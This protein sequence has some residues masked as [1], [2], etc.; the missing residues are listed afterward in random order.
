VK[1][2]N[3]AYFAN[4]FMRISMT[5]CPGP[6][7]N[8]WQVAGVTWHRDRHSYY[9][10]DYSF[11]CD[12]HTLS[13]AGRRAWGLLYVNETWWDEKGKNVVRSTHWGRLL[14]GSKT[15]V[16]AWFKAQEG[17]LPT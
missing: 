15:D 12:I 2:F 16:F 8:N 17:A 4:S 10:Q 13:F 9:G 11:Q 5:T 7:I 3:D 6:Q 1:T 14:R